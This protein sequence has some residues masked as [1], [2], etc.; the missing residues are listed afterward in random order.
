MPNLKPLFFGQKQKLFALS[1]KSFF[2]TD[3]LPEGGK[4]YINGKWM[5]SIGATTFE[6]KNPYSKEVITE[7]ANC[8]QS[9]AQIAVQAAREAFQK[10]GFET[11][12]KERGA[13]L[14]KWYQILT[15]KEEELAKILTMEQGKTLAEA[16]GEIQYSAS[17]FDYYAGEARRIR[18]E[19]VPAPVLNRQHFHTR[20]PIGVV[21]VITP[22]NF[23]TAMIARKAAAALAAGCTLVVKPA[24]ETPLSAL[25]LAQT[26]EEAGLP[27]GVFN[28][29]PADHDRIADISKY[30]CQSHD[31]NCISF[32]GSTGVGRLLLSQSAST[33]KRVCLELGG[34]APFIV[35]ESADI[36]IAVQSAIASKFRCSGQTCVSANRFYIHSKVHDSFVQKLGEAMSKFVCGNGMDQNTTQGPLIHEKA[37]EKVQKLVDNAVSKGAKIVKG[38]KIIENTTCFEPTILTNVN[39]SMEIANE[40]IFGPVVAIQ[41]FETEDEAIQ[42]AN[43]TRLG[44]AAYFF[45]NCMKQTFR[46][47]RRIESGMIGINEGAISSAE[48]AFGGVKESGLGREGGSQGIEE[49]AQWKYIC[50][51]T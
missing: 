11:T 18:G 23:P 3:R 46:V 24:A 30:L 22:W 32:T 34:N 45:T 40:E 39:E 29:I 19:I 26:A 50:L 9:D 43:S 5:D 17:Y 36:D 35:F 37:V 41:S 20:E 8:D 31:V 42:K 10:W 12:G 47:S 49:F 27:K 6:V 15:E 44:L 28:V 13:I 38:G 2:H 1:Q 33:V 51:K 25:A 4:A 14:N 16:K 48:A 7:V 21:A